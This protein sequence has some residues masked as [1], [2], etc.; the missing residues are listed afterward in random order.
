MIQAGTISTGSAPT[1]GVAGA[2]W[3]SSIS[4]LRNTTLPGVT[5]RFLPT[6][7]PFARVRRRL[8]RGLIV[9]EVVHPVARRLRPPVVR[10]ASIT[11]GLSQGT[12]DG[13]IRSSHCRTVNATMRSLRGLTPSGLRTTLVPPFLA[14]Q[15]RLGEQ[16]RTGAAARPDR[17]SGGH[18]PVVRSAKPYRRRCASGAPIA[19]SPGAPVP[20]SGTAR[21]PRAPPSRGRRER[22]VLG[23]RPPVKRLCQA[24]S[25][26]SRSAGDAGFTSP[27]VWLSGCGT[28]NRAG[29]P[30]SGMAKTPS[31]FIDMKCFLVGRFA[32]HDGS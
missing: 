16:G 13:D 19:P 5:A 10:V 21:S 18:P 26:R 28:D 23:D 25:R 14:K 9:Q 15:H 1:F 22:R 11:S 27:A 29:V 7:K 31:S 6:V 2:Y 30:S 24:C 17:R 8:R 3:I 4:A 32:W 12:L 20:W